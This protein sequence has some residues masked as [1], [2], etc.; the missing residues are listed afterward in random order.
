[1]SEASR[2]SRQPPARF[3]E[4]SLVKILE[5]KDI[6]RPSTYAPIVA[7]LLARKY[8]SREKKTLVPTELGFIVTDMMEE[9]FKEI[10]DTAFTSN[11]E[12]RLDQI[13]IRD[14]DWKDIIREF[15]SGFE[16]ELK[17]ADEKIEKVEFEDQMTDEICDKCG[18]HMVI[19]HGRFGSFLACSGYP[20][21]K[22]TK[23]IVVFYGCEVSSVRE[24][25]CRETQQK[26]K[27]VLRMQR[28]SG[29]HS[30]L[31]GQTGER[32]VPEMRVAAR[33]EKIQDCKVCVL[34]QRVRL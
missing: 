12:D 5:E 19:K 20:D 28:L 26:G 17:Y 14:T 34:E 7:T 13:E 33:G 23:P 30:A 2:V 27:S 24:R 6:G 15:Y 8:I 32:E 11:M 22:N 21:C 9:Y 18:K 25:Y 16:K 31:L 1:M 4:A 29:L 10:V 3:T